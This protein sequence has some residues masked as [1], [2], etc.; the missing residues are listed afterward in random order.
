LVAGDVTSFPVKQGGIATQQA[1]AAAEAI[2]ADL[3]AIAEA[4]PFRPVL[5]GEIA[6][7]MQERDVG[8]ALAADFGRLIG[9]SPHAIW[10]ERSPAGCTRARR[11][12]ESG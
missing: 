7:R 3:G 2:A 9:I 11:A 5:R 12:R 10:C 8:S 6:R 4:H 1:D